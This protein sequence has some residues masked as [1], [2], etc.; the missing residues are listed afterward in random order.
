MRPLVLLH[1]FLGAPAAWDGVLDALRYQGPVL[2]P[3][4][5]G[6][7]GAPVVASFQ[8]EVDRLAAAIEDA[9]LRDAHLVGYSLGG[10]LAT[11]LLATHPERF[12]RATLLSAH[13]GLRTEPE[14]QARRAS[15]GAWANRLAREGLDPFLDAW[16]AQALFDSQAALPEPARA[17]WRRLRAAHDPASVAVGLGPLSLGEMPDYTSRLAGLAA[18][19]TVLTGALDLKFLALAPALCALFPRSAR[20]SIPGAGHNLPLEAPSAVAE[21]LHRSPP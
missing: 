3:A 14:R 21:A 17:A 7:A 1:G 15:D 11:G 8:A 4:L 12:S 18:P 10:R 9:G 2:A 19:V 20:H 5:S 13:P 16:E 6:H